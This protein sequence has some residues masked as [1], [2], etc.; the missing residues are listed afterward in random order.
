[1]AIFSVGANRQIGFEQAPVTKSEPLQLQFAA[2]LDSVE[3]RNPPKCSGRAARQSLGVAL[4]I[5]DKIEEHSEVVSRSLEA[6]WK[7]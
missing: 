7:P 3:S 4:S 6:G 2:F 5:L 1:L